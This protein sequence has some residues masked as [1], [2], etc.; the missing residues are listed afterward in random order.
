MALRIAGTVTLLQVFDMPTALHFYRDLLGFGVVQ[1]SAPTDQCDW[2]WLR[3]GDAEVMLNTAYEA[4]L[5][6]AV[7]DPERQRAHDDTTLF[8]GCPEVDAAYAYLRSQG[9]AASP[10][11]T[12]PYG[13]RQVFLHDPDGFGL[14]LQW[15]AAPGAAVA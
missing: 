3:H 11:K 15:P 4:G 9:I 12:A 1:Q 6:P 2:V 5:R 14:C 7:P 8:L 10:P 13:M